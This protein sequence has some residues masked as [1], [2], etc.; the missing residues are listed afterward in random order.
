MTE[1]R[2]LI[3]EKLKQLLIESSPVIEE[4]TAL[5]CPGCT[6]VCCKQKHGTFR[7]NDILYLRALGVEAPR[8][9]QERSP[10]GPCEWMGTAGCDQPRWLRPFK[11]TWYFCEPLLK[12]LNEGPPRKAR[13]VSAL[14]QEMAD[15]YGEL[16]DGYSNPGK[17]R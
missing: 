9:D 11:C 10:E 3:A 12:A 5:I 8:R 7:E 13:Q 15:R 6:D 1:T 2:T 14:L 17:P 4:Y 16:G